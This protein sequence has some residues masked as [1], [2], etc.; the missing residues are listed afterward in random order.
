MRPA[1]QLSGIVKLTA[2]YAPA[3]QLHR[4]SPLAFVMKVRN[5]EKRT[6]LLDPG[7]S[8]PRSDR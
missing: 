2:V 1:F 7:H 3:S 6:Q 5:V 8:K 4:K